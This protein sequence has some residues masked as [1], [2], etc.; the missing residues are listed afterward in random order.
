MFIEKSVVRLKIVLGFRRCHQPNK[1]H[2]LRV[3]YCNM[4]FMSSWYYGFSCVCVMSWN[5]SVERKRPVSLRP[6]TA[7]VTFLLQHDAKCCWKFY[8]KTYI[9]QSRHMNREV[10]PEL[11]LFRGE[12]VCRIS[13]LGWESEGAE[14]DTRTEE[15]N[16]GM[17]CGGHRTAELAT[18]EAYIHR[19]KK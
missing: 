17:N 18:F 1:G 2:C 6:L 9:Y 15:M 10:V 16:W 5:I 12:K 4:S 13:E 7:Y 19:K 11:T 14:V 3:E 8:A